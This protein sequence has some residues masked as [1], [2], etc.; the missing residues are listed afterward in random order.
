MKKLLSLMLVLCMAFSAMP[1]FAAE[2]EESSQTKIPDTW[3]IMSK[4]NSTSQFWV[5]I[6]GDVCTI[7]AVAEHRDGELTVPFK[8]IFKVKDNASYTYGDSVEINTTLIDK[9]AF[10]KGAEGVTTI[11]FDDGF[12]I[13]PDGLCEG[14]KDLT[15]VNLPKSL[16]AIG[17]NCFK[18]CAMLENINLENVQ[19]MGTDAFLGTKITTEKE[20]TAEKFEYNDPIR[21]LSVLG[22]MEGYENGDFKPDEYLT[23]AE[24]AKIVVKLLKLDD[25]AEQ[26]ETMFF[27]VPAGHWASGY[28]NV[29]TAN[30]IIYGMGDGNFCPDASVTYCQMIKMLVAATGWEPVAEGFGGW[31]G[32]GYL[33]AAQEAGIINETPCFIYTRVTRGEVA[34]LCY[35]TLTVNLRDQTCWQEVTDKTILSAYWDMEVIEGKIGTVDDGKVFVRIT[36]NSASYEV[37]KVYSFEVADKTVTLNGGQMIKAIAMEDENVIAVVVDISE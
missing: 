35:D 19:Y 11:T 20:E 3:K 13:L 5:E 30:G 14:M 17:N 28:I 26:G 33:I 15:T 8:G 37:G 7:M 21:I 6:E 23:R 27:D 29:A 1:I 18:D 34:Q 32:G 12:E 9:D 25:E 24:A 2:T 10:K 4:W 31:N 22:I 16:Y 36:S